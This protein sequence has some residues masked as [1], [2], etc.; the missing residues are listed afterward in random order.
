MQ[1]NHQPIKIAKKGKE[2]GVKVN[3]RVR[4]GDQVFEEKR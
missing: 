3:D 1:Y 4:E 2:V